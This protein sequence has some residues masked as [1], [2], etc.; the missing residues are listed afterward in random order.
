ME[1]PP[2]KLPP[3]KFPSINLHS[4]VNSPQK[5]PTKF[6]PGIVS[7]ISLIRMYLRGSDSHLILPFVHKQGKEGVYSLS[8]LDDNV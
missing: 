4:P 7:P 3:G 2:G 1:I 8:L 6:P 5:I